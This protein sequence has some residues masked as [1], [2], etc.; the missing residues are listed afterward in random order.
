MR[1]PGERQKQHVVSKL[2]VPNSSVS[3]SSC[4]LINFFISETQDIWSL[5][6]GLGSRVFMLTGLFNQSQGAARSFLP[7]EIHRIGT[8]GITIPIGG[9][10]T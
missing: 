3:H 5:A 8:C 4:L 6:W 7:C 2:V 9:H 1:G 10:F